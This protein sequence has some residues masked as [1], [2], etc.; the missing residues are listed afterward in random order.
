MYKKVIFLKDLPSNILSEAILV[1]K[2]DVIVNDDINTNANNIKIDS[3]IQEAKYIIQECMY[4]IEKESQSKKS[5]LH[6]IIDKVR[7]CSNK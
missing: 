1:F 3:A 6:R 5:F 4:K 2:E 7:G